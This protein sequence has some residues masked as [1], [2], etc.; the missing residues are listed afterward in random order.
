VGY[1]MEG[2]GHGPVKRKP[3]AE[4]AFLDRWGNNWRG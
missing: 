3:V 2:F 1:P 4:V